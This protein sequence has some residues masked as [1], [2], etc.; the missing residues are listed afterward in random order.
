MF[1]VFNLRKNLKYFK[2]IAVI[3]SI[4]ILG[5]FVINRLYPVKYLDI[6]YKYSKMYG[7]DPAFVCSVINAESSF[8]KNAVSDK[9]ASGLMQLMKPTADWAAEE[10]GFENYNYKDIFDVEINIH[11]GC[12]YLSRLMKQFD[13]D[14]TL[15]LAAYNAGSGNVSKWLYDTRYSKDGE[16]LDNIPYKATNKY[17][18][19]VTK[20][21][22]VYKWILKAFGG[23][24]EK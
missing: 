8:N 23:K 18:K 9:G 17:V 22:K 21:Q 10:I 4:I 14:L 20:N 13:N 15:V 24:Y 3:M 19:D 1:Y 5:V 2:F 7:I 16:Q 12:W 6:I 11:I